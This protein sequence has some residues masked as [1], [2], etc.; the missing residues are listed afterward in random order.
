MTLVVEFTIP[1]ETFAAG[2][3]FADCGI[4]AVELERVVPT[5]DALLPFLWT[6]GDDL[7]AYEGRLAAEPGVAGVTR[8]AETDDGR[9][10]RVEW[11]E[12]RSSAIRE[13]FE[14]EFTLL[15]GVCSEGGWT[16]E[17][18][19][20]SSDAAAAFRRALASYRI[21]YDLTKVTNGATGVTEASYGLTDDQRDILV[22]AARRGY[23]EEPRRAT[24]S[25]VATELGISV[26]SASGRLR[27]AQDA[28][29]RNTVL[30]ELAASDPR[31]PAGSDAS[32]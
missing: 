1:L 12:D 23:F 20:P 25:E 21:P 31:P 19:F 13:L 22:V 29:V 14:Y 30:D 17:V 16:F 7:D 3:A 6:R 4:D 32:F 10:Y 11:L 5:D 18:R 24:L 8:L 15:S 27:R 28:L 2:R 9:L 26:S